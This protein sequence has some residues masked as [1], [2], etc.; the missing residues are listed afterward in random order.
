[1]PF[2]KGIAMRDR[3]N[4]SL[5]AMLGAMMF[6]AG[7]G[8]GGSSP[9]SAPAS[10][11]TPAPAARSNVSLDK[12]SYPVFPNADAGADPS[13]PAEQGGKG[14]KGEGWT[15]N[16]DFDLI[17]DPRAVKGGVLK[18]AMMT[19]FPSTLRYYGPNISA[20]NFML[21]SMVYESLLSMNPNTLTYIPSLASHWQISP[22]KQTFRFRINPNAKWSDGVP[23]TSEDVIASWKL[24]VDKG[25]Q[26]PARTLVYVNFEPPIAE[27]KYIVS[28]KAKNVNWLNF[29]YFSSDMFI[30]PAHVLKNVSG[31]D[32]IRDWNYKLLPGTGPYIVNDQDVNKGNS[33]RIH[34]RKDY[35][36]EN[37]RRNVGTSNFDEVQQL[38]VRDRNL[39]FERFKKGDL[40]YYFVQR[41]QMWVQELNYPNIKRGLNQKRK[42]FNNNPNGLQ[43]FA[44]NTRKE[45]YNDIRV[46]RALAHL[47]NRD[48]MIQ[49]LIFNE[50][51][52]MN[53]MYPGSVY[54]NPSNEK[55]MYD[56]QKAIQLLAEAG[57]KDR[58]SAGRL[59]KGGRPLTIELVY[60]DQASE[61]YFTIYQ[62]DL[63]KVGITLN[64]RFITWETLIKLLDDRAFDM[65][66]MAYTGV[67]FPSPE[68]ELHSS[69]ADVKNT[70][71]ITGFKNKRA[72]E[73]MEAYKKEFDFNARVKLLREL[74]GIVMG[75]HH[76]ILEWTA[77]YQRI[78][79]WNKFG[80][81]K[82]IVS[83]TGDYRDMP[84]LWWI[85]PD[86]AQKLDQAQRDQ[87]M[88]LGEG[89]SDDKYWLEYS[90]REGLTDQAPK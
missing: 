39:E 18:Q 25:L 68:Q 67:V 85:D 52:P 23:V 86:K 30:Y 65:S 51:V 64:L 55:V 79:F 13:V 49:K 46:R 74:D 41:A 83:R 16:T 57:W 54:E 19:D 1:V 34:R 12:N 58:D 84:S 15:T 10:S 4:I 31:A 48:L 38:V 73:I 76:W 21:H 70:N 50:Y 40:D 29:L 44:M 80:Y 22:D 7:C 35:W 69:L 5:A 88:Q 3:V 75:E 56:P 59:V 77:P 37:D 71:N 9:S 32:Y 60:A 28:V 72:D 26:D 63:R 53:S 82:G 90:Q 81:P 45:P 43:G 8:G 11:S 24:T 89:P 66:S 27:S 33:I 2:L 87:S 61:R 78:V 47:F 20:W 14:F 36:A 42:I 6:V 17:G 62:E